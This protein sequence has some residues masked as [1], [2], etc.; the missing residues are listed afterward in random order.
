MDVMDAFVLNDRQ[1]HLIFESLKHCRHV[2]AKESGAED[3]EDELTAVMRVF[4][5]R[6]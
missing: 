6:D 4:A 5:E 3:I 1:Q 2:L